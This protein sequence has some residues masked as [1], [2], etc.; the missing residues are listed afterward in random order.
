MSVSKFLN[1]I[2]MRWSFGSNTYRL[3]FSAAFSSLLLLPL[4]SCAIEPVDAAVTV[5]TWNVGFIDRNVGDLD[6]P[7]F[8]NEVDFD[9]LLV[10]EVQQQSDLDALK[11]AMGREAF[12]TSIST[13]VPGSSNPG[14]LEVGI[15]SRFPLDNIVEFD[16]SPDNAGDNIERRLERV[17]QPGIADVGVG[18][19]F[20]V[21]EVPELNLFVIV[22]HFKS[23]RG[24]SG[25]SDFGNA[26]KR[27]LV[28]AAVA[29]HALQLLE[30]NPGHTVLFGGDV[31]VGVADSTKNGT[32]LTD[33]RNDGYDD[34]HALLGG[35]LI[36][37]LR[38]RS[39]AQAVD[40]TFVGDDN[41]PDFPGTGAIDVLYAVGE[42]AE[43][44]SPAVA[45]SDRYGSDHLAV[46]A[47]LAS[48]PLS[49]PEPSDP[50]VTPPA[51]EDTSSIVQEE[52][53][54]VTI[55]N[56]LPNPEGSDAGRETVTLTYQG[57]EALDISAWALQDEAGNQFSFPIGTTL[58]AGDN[59]FM[60]QPPTM[61]L[62]NDG[63]TII[64]LDSDGIQHG[65]AFTYSSQEVVAGQLIR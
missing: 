63:D 21:A 2:D 51:P 27:E 58:V 59:E 13:F 32:D 4:S 35:G 60:L 53:S 34:T 17:D 56:A 48:M 55:S 30:E 7:D 50:S 42:L 24:Q 37:G 61:P 33:D 20:L 6:I 11:A 47:S 28:A 22:S 39:L 10:N 36:D 46:F 9:I 8:L 18:R 16:R 15:I 25:P 40:S 38:M 5:A 26:Q 12:F 23:S 54:L 65:E 62:N 52:E 57:T 19:G 64:L 49:D 45:T 43:A 29:T 1:C 44:F 31:N 41:I 14:D 3:L